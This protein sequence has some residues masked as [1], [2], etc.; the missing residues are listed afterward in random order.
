MSDEVSPYKAIVL[1][2]NGVLLSYGNAAFVS[3]LKLRHIK[4]I[5]DSPTWYEYE[6][7]RSSRKECYSTVASEFGLDVDTWTQTLDQLTEDD[8]KIYGMTTVLP[9]LYHLSHGRLVY[10]IKEIH[11]HHGPVVRIAPNELPSTDPQAWRDIFSHGKHK[12][13]SP[14]IAFYNPYNDQ[15]PSI[16]S[17]S[18]DAH[19]ELRKRL[20]GGFSEMAMRAQEGLIGGYVDLLMRRLR[21]NSVDS[22]GRP[23]SVNM[24][25]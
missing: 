9:K 7:G 13:L 23:Q 6:C 21:E 1:D 22:S 11:T 19:H 4:N 14:D 3:P 8:V 17:S 15:P 10:H 12:G 18:D 2:L 5:F 25:D 24:R 16:I 20:S